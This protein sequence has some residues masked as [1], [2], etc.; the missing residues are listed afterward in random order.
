VPA[1]KFIDA[2]EV[3]AFL[4]GENESIQ[5]VLAHGAIA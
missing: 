5:S 2:N 3:L 1:Q 4:S